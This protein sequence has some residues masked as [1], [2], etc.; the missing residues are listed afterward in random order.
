MIYER[1]LFLH[2]LQFIKGYSAAI[3][4]FVIPIPVLAY[5]HLVNVNLNKKIKLKFGGNKN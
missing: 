5:L 4:F 2:S 3:A 1:I